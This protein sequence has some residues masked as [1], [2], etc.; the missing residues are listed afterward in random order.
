MKGTIVQALLITLAISLV[1]SA[2]MFF[3]A[4]S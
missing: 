4:G 3:G 2:V 1:L